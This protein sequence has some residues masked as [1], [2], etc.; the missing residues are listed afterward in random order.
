MSTGCPRIGAPNPK[1]LAA[2]EFGKQLANALPVAARAVANKRL[3]ALTGSAVVIRTI[4]HKMLYDVTEFWVE[5]ASQ[6][7]SRSRTTT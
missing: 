3:S 5:A 7:R 4:P 6:S 1:S 2:L